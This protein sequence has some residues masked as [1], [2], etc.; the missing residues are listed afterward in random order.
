[1]NEDLTTYRR[2]FP[3]TKRYA[4]LDH[5]ST[6]PIPTP[7]QDAMQ[8]LIRARTVGQEWEDESDSV[9]PHV[10]EMCA[11]LV[12]GKPEVYAACLPLLEVM[13][14]IVTLIGPNGAGQTTKLCNQVAGALNNLAV[15]EALMLAA[16]SGLD[17]DKVLAAISG[18]AAG[19]WMMTNIAPKILAGDFSPGFMVDLQQKDL[20]LVVE[21]AHDV[22]LSMPGVSVVQQCLNAVQ[23][24]GLGRDGIQALIKAYELQHGVQ[25][26]S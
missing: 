8:R 13:G 4:F 1:M 9:I 2:L 5:A 26:R 17:V 21:A 18:G 25:A 24:A 12:G 14:K 19:S 7:V 22:R 3:I 11:R 16:A 6:A 20:K 10:R 23:R 15:A